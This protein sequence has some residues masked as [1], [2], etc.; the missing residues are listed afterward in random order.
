MKSTIIVVFVLAFNAMYTNAIYGQRNISILDVQQ[1]TC[2][3]HASGPSSAGVE[4]LA[5]NGTIVELRDDRLFKTGQ[6]DL[7][8]T[9]TIRSSFHHGPSDWMY[10]GADG[11]KMYRWK[12]GL[13]VDSISTP[14]Q[15][16]IL[17]IR[18]H[19]SSIL[20]RTTSGQ[21][22]S[23]LSE[24][25]SVD[26]VMAPY[27]VWAI[28]PFTDG[29]HAIGLDSMITYTR[30][31]GQ[32]TTRS[33]LSIA[34]GSSPYTAVSTDDGDLVVLATI[35]N[36][37]VFCL[38]RS[39]R[40]S[41]PMLV[42]TSVTPFALVSRESSIAVVS[43][44]GIR[45]FT[46][47]IETFAALPLEALE[48]YEF[49]S[50]TCIEYGN[51][52]IV[53]GSHSFIAEIS[54]S[55][56][57]KVR[58]YLPRI[59]ARGM[60]IMS[61]GD[62]VAGIRGGRVR[63]VVAP[64]RTIFEWTPL[65]I[66]GPCLGRNATLSRQAFIGGGE[67]MSTWYVMDPNITFSRGWSNPVSCHKSSIAPDFWTENE[68]GDMYGLSATDTFVVKS[69]D[70]GRSWSRYCPL[71]GP[72]GLNGN[73]FAKNDSLWIFSGGN[74]T[75]DTAIYQSRS[76]VRIRMFKN[77]ILKSDTSFHTISWI[78]SS[79]M[80]DGRLYAIAGSNLVSTAHPLRSF[81]YFDL[82]NHT[83]TT[84]YGD[85]N[86]RLNAFAFFGTHAVFTD[87]S[88]NIYSYGTGAADSTMRLI[89]ANLGFGAIEQLFA[90][91]DTTAL[92]ATAEVLKSIYAITFH[93]QTTSVQDHDPYLN[94]R[95]AS[96]DDAFPNP[97]NSEVKLRLT[98]ANGWPMADITIVVSSVLGQLLVNQ[99]LSTLTS[100]PSNGTPIDIVLPCSGWPTGSYVVSARSSRGRHSKVVIKL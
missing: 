97:T 5:D 77:G 1:L 30:D 20:V 78:R 8:S 65:P 7:P 35:R 89:G 24:P 49:R 15:S 100:A 2:T 81:G 39:I 9:T 21:V 62:K 60:T 38:Y 34:I 66:R 6:I 27:M 55:L 95:I 73:I 94:L 69:S 70:R 57:W 3:F 98:I 29:Y 44:E 48:V 76:Y 61:Q 63:S 25:L 88:G 90:L 59:P 42:D 80:H 40:N 82:S 79:C 46:D 56:G 64:G 32:F 72:P 16:T 52:F 58:S 99:S 96:I 14:D 37:G 45:T 41:K 50:T 53:A 18:R 33:S 10:V 28:A 68:S 4:F 31:A 71:S 19:N 43:A 87:I 92:L 93:Q 12:S 75:L 47:T 51:S 54:D 84:L 26:T 23:F 74:D 67:I 91:N 86:I 36:D 11:S 85:E 83:F 13:L 22:I 17:E